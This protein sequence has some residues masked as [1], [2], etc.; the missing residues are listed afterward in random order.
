MPTK[1]LKATSK[2][3]VTLPKKWRQRFDTDNFFAEIEADRII[4][5]PLELEDENWETVF[6]ANRH[7]N[8]KGISV[9]DMI[10]SLKKL[11]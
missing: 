9:E 7:N 1:I 4:I 2:G 3:Q 5:K 8:G 10:K 11:M 6:D